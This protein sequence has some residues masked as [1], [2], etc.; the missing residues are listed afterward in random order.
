MSSTK[1]ETIF[2]ERESEDIPEVEELYSMDD[3]EF[4]FTALQYDFVDAV[5]GHEIMI[6]Q[7]MDS[8][9]GDYR[10]LDEELQSVDVGVAFD[11]DNP[12]DA[13]IG[14]EQAL[15]D[16]RDDGTLAQILE[17]YGI[18][19]DSTELEFYCRR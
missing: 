18:I 17:T 6:R 14:L 19:A 4:V 1:P 7:Y 9:A 15:S 8:M 10:L 12:S 3:M 5:A 2:L 13:V 16:M 11:K